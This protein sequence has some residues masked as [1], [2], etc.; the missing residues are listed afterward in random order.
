MIIQLHNFVFISVVALLN[1]P[2]FNISESDFSA[3]GYYNT[4]GQSFPPHCSRVTCACDRSDGCSDGAW[5]AAWTAETPLDDQRWIQV[6]NFN[7]LTC[8]TCTN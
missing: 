6:F 4:H 1:S 7:F 3:S 5:A 2:D 8:S